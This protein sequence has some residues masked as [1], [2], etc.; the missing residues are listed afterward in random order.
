MSFDHPRI[1]IS[2]PNASGKSTLANAIGEKFQVPVIAEGY[3]PIIAAK[4]RYQT[5]RKDGAPE[6]DVLH[7]KKA[8]INAFIR[9]VKQREAE[10]EKLPAFV[11]DRWEA[12]L[13]DMWLV[14]MRNETD[15]DP[16][17]LQF[18][19]NL[20]ARAK[21]MDLVI[22]MPISAPL[23]GEKNDAD[24]VRNGTLTNR[25]LNSMVTTGIILN[26]PN[27]RVL[28]IPSVS[29]SVDERLA[30]VEKAVSDMK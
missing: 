21:G 25:L 16:L 17:T 26:I 30:L 15:L 4:M 1:V 8:W 9:W 2:G 20:Y 27:L 24:I 29:M 7:A 10:Y 22:I 12:D 28:K 3:V 18:V 13:L 19:K 6:A 5:L 11:A 23:P 14:F